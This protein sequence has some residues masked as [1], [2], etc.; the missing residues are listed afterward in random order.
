MISQDMT[1]I[2]MDAMELLSF[3]LPKLPNLMVLQIQETTAHC[4]LKYYSKSDG[5][6]EC[7]STTDS[8]YCVSVKTKTN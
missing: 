4:T 3:P 5:H 1:K 7:L 6:K 2:N 8:L